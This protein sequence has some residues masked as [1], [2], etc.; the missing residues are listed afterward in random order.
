VE[1]SDA[2][3]SGGR[4]ME[5]EKEAEVII[6]HH[7]IG[8]TLHSNMSDGLKAMLN[9][10]AELAFRCVILNGFKG[11]KAVKETEGIVLIDEL[12]MHLHPNWQM[13]VVKDLKNAFPSIQFIVTSHSPPAKR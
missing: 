3:N 6:D 12:D 2:G 5:E 13:H 11:E 7:T 1:S 4:G 9:L 8:K 10:V